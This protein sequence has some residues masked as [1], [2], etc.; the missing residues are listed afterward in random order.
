MFIFQELKANINCLTQ[1]EEKNVEIANEFLISQ[2]ITEDLQTKRK[3]LV[4]FIAFLQ[5]NRHMKYL[6]QKTRETS[7]DLKVPVYIDFPLPV[8]LQIQGLL[9]QTENQI[10]LMN[11][12]VDN[13]LLSRCKY[14]KSQSK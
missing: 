11:F 5:K 4:N 9:S 6:R 3:L 7:S 10:H 12:I 2:D 14:E 8:G 1:I 13:L